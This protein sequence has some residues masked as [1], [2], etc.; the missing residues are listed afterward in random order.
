MRKTCQPALV[1]T[2]GW[3]VFLITVVQPDAVVRAAKRETAHLC[4]G[5]T[6]RLHTA[7]LQRRLRVA[8]LVLHGTQRPE[9]VELSLEQLHTAP[10]PESAHPHLTGRH[11]LPV[12]DLA[13]E[14]S[15]VLAGQLSLGRCTLIQVFK[16]EESIGVSS[17]RRGPLDI[18]V[19]KATV[20]V[21]YPFHFLLRDSELEVSGEERAGG[22]R[23]LLGRQVIKVVREPVLLVLSPAGPRYRPTVVLTLPT[24]RRP[25]K[26]ISAAPAPTSVLAA[27][28]VRAGRWAGL[29]VPALLVPVVGPGR[30]A[31]RLPVLRHPLHHRGAVHQRHPAR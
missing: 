8:R 7:V 30:G 25:S 31:R 2:A 29:V 18:N 4:H 9:P 15:G 19:H 14:L 1:A 10:R 5:R 26:I 13:L 12:P 11:N 6:G 23:V 21:E 22:E 16:P 28:A 17:T 24:R 27:A 3:H 20:P